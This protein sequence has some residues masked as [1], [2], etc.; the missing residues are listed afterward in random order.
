[1]SA[2]WAAS[3]SGIS[4]RLE[5]GRT[6]RVWA[7]YIRGPTPSVAE[8]PVRVLDEV[9]VDPGGPAIDVELAGALP[10][11]RIVWLL[12]GGAALKDEQ[13]GEGFGAGG[14][15]VRAGGE[16]H[17]S[18]QLAEL[19]DLAAGGRVGRVEREAACEHSD[20]AA[21][22]GQRE[23]FE[24]EVVVQAVPT[25]VVP[26]VV[27]A[28]VGERHVPDCGVEESVRQPRICEGLAANLRLRVEHCGDRRGGRVELDPRH[29][30]AFG[31]ERDEHA[32][33]CAGL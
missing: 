18:E 23:R 5:V 32:R 4:V 22:A 14:A 30:G 15:A 17:G 33:A 24:D 2:S 8:D 26:G 31:R 13:V 20:Q 28:H 21:G 29:F 16:P 1:M 6:W 12:A 10:V 19:V 3:C 25:R 9:A 11:G 7:P 27:Q